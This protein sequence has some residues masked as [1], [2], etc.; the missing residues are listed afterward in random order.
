MCGLIKTGVRTDKGFREV[1]LAVVAKA[2]FEHCGIDVS[3]TQVYNHL[4]KWRQRWL[5][6]TRLRDLSGT[7][8]CDNTKCIILEDEH[9]C[10]HVADHPKDA[11]FLNVPIANYGGM[12]TIL[13]FGLASDKYVMG[14]SEPL[15]TAVATPSLKDVETQKYD[16]II[17]D[18][19]PEKGA[20][21]PDK[22]TAGK[23]KRGAFVDD[24]LVAFTNMNV[25]VKDVAEAIEDNKPTYTCSLT[26][27][28][29]SWACL[30]SPRRIS[31][32]R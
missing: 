27:T 11:E 18:G 29:R 30:A 20:D 8:W 23:S 15:G 26:Y 10:G 24:E 2:L 17:I 7:Q 13:S 9:Y 22:A 1:Y 14:S 16:T 12:H 21:A 28:I 5:T 31:W 6:I 3:F 32:Q 19:P 4:R 25:F